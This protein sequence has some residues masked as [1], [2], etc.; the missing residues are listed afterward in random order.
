MRAIL[1]RVSQA[2]VT[3]E[4][5]AT[6][7]IGQGFL[8]LL[9][10]ENGDTEQE[11]KLLCDK[12]AALRVF[13][14]ENGKL[15]LSCLDIGGEI[16][17]ISNFTLCADCRKGRRPSFMGAAAPG[18][19]EPLYG[20]FCEQLSQNGVKRVARGVFGADMKVSLINDG[21]VTILLDTKELKGQ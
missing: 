12:T 16:L 21:P 5:K 19:A 1:Q 6:A 4:G 14:D 9:G 3:I 13:E 18:E 7:S 17:V 20:R 11:A 2:S 10:V 8:V 15:N